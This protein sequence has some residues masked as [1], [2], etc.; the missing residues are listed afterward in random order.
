ML[1][2]GC[3]LDDI[4]ADILY[5]IYYMKLGNMPVRCNGRNKICVI[6]TL[7]SSNYS[8]QQV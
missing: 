7:L 4:T 1:E 2:G 5:P 3:R 6:E 8:K